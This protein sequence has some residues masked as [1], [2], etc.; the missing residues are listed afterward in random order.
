MTQK[1]ILFDLDG[2]LTDS[3]EGIMNC[4]AL[5]LEH[6][7][8]PVPSREAMRVFVGP[9]LTSTFRSFGIPEEKIPEAV[10]VFRSRYTP[11]GIFENS[12]YPGIHQLMDTLSRHGHKLYVATSKPEEMAITVLRHFELEQFFTGICGAAMDESR[13][14]KEEVI[15]YLLEK[16][17]TADN[18]L[19]IGDTVFDVLGAASHGIPT[20][21]VSWGYGDPEEMRR[22]GAIAVATNMDE[23][24]NLIEAE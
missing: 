3:G 17:G 6:F 5:A 22:A 21:G 16:N 15:A 8:I 14:N 11:V 7:H 20:I 4:A 13:T 2:T 10:K 12:P 1:T 23:L 18:M 9:P 24:L 19:M